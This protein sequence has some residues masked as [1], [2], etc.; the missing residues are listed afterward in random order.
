MPKCKMKH[1]CADI[2]SCQSADHL[3]RVSRFSWNRV[4][5]SSV[6]IS[7]YN[8]TSSAYNLH[9]VSASNILHT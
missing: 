6:T 7:E 2:V 8:L 5:S 1:F 9:L 4:W 3:V